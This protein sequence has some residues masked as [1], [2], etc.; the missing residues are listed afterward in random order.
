MPKLKLI[1]ATP[2]RVAAFG[3]TAIGAVL[4]ISFPAEYKLTKASNGCPL[5]PAP[6]AAGLY[7]CKYTR[8]L[9]PEL[10]T[11]VTLGITLLS[12]CTSGLTASSLLLS[13]ALAA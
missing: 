5:M 8:M 3:S 9:R 11:R 12:P 6:D 10:K 4:Y 13:F 1:G 7:A 2:R